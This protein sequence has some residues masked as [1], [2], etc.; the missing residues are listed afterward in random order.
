MTSVRLTNAVAHANMLHSVMQHASGARR[1]VVQER[2]VPWILERQAD[3]FGDKPLLRGGGEEWSYRETLS[4]AAAL[5]SDLRSA[6][7]EPGER[8]AIMCGNR[9]DLIRVWLGCGWSGLIAVPINT[10]LRGRQLQHVLVDSGA[11]LLVIEPSYLQHLELIE[12][13]LPQLE[14]LWTVGAEPSPT[15]W[16]KRS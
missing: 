8:V 4:K 10:A 15:S 3:A 9:P 1:R 6:G 5:S 2:T 12:S 13:P 7:L 14:R 16:R 11:S